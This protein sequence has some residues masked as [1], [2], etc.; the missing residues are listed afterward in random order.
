MLA[1]I[2]GYQKIAPPHLQIQFTLNTISVTKTQMPRRLWEARAAP[3]LENGF[4]FNYRK[5]D[6]IMERARAASLPRCRGPR[7]D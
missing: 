4:H 3:R 6:R 7:R 2:P 1:F 5:N